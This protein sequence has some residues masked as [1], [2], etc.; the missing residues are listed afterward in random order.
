MVFRIWRCLNIEHS[1]VRHQG[2][3]LLYR[4]CSVRY[5]PRASWGLAFEGMH[6]LHCL[7]PDHLDARI[8]HFISLCGGSAVSSLTTHGMLDAT[9]CKLSLVT[10]AL[11]IGFSQHTLTNWLESCGGCCTARKL[12]SVQSHT[13]SQAINR[14]L[15]LEY[16]ECDCQPTCAGIHDIVCMS[17]VTWVADHVRICG[18]SAGCWLL[19][20]DK[21]S[22]QKQ[23]LLFFFS[24]SFRGALVLA[25]ALTA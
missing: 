15:L 21:H 14:V 2:T 22:M 23:H 4:H 11:S 13:N 8:L 3:S 20:L 19:I 7:C 6:C 25:L 9:R 10:L 12:C 5:Q 17:T 24:S 18:H 16:V 1:T